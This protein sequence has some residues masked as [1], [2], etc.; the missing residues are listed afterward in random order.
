MYS[1]E[2]LTSVVTKWSYMQGDLYAPV[3]FD[4][5]HGNN[6]STWEMQGVRNLYTFFTLNVCPKYHR[7]LFNIWIF[8]KLYHISE[9]L[10][11]I[12]IIPFFEYLLSTYYTYF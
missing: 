9:Y 11:I 6:R 5:I 12:S 8:Y 4:L 1:Y 3:N 2:E 7:L 10:Y